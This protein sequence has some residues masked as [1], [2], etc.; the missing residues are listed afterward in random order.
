MLT[1]G[2]QI[3]TYLMRTDFISVDISSFYT[4]LLC[5][6]KIPLFVKCIYLSIKATKV[7]TLNKDRS[8]RVVIK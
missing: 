7:K 4:K 5:F 1:K 3:L 2:K 6:I 8:A